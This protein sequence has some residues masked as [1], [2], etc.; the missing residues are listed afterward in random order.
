MTS[1]VPRPSLMD[2]PVEMLEAIVAEVQG[3]RD[4]LSL[5]QTCRLLSCIAQPQLYTSMYVVG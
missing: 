5:T 1:P 2:M 3:K 4:L